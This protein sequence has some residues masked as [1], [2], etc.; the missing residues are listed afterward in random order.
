MKNNPT[1]SDEYRLYVVSF[2]YKGSSHY[3]LWGFDEETEADK[4]LLDKNRL[5]NTFSF[6]AEMA[7]FLNANKQGI[8]DDPKIK[9]WAAQINED[10]DVAVYDIDALIHILKKR[11]NDLNKNDK[12]ALLNFGNICSDYAYQ[13]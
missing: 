12:I 3:S 8:F 2:I 6:I 7:T 13:T 1:I 4:L 10:L 5:I 11:F 9:K